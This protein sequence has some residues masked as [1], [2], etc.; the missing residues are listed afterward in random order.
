[1]AEGIDIAEDSLRTSAASGGATPA[2]YRRR[3]QQWYR[4]RLFK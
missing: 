1:M 2:D 3:L 4:Q